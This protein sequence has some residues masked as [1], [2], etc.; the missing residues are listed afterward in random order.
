MFKNHEMRSGL[1][2]SCVA[3]RMSDPTTIFANWQFAGI[4][5]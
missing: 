3:V 2:A 4:C 1:V 5:S